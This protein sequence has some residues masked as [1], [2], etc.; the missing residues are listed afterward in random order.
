MV[1]AVQPV[2][3]KAGLLIKLETSQ[4]HCVFKQAEE[5]EGMIPVTVG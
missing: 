3:G 5:G 2:Y 4:S 1:P